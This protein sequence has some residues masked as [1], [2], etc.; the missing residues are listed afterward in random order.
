MTVYGGFAA[1]TLGMLSQ[2]HALDT[3]GNNIANINTGGFR[4]TETR[5][6]TVLSDTV[7]GINSLQSDLGGVRPL[8]INRIDQQGRLI[9]SQNPLDVA[10]SGQGFFVLNTQLNGSGETLYTRDGAFNIGN[11]PL[12]TATADDG[13]TLSVHEG[14][15]VDKNGYF[16]QGWTAAADGTFPTSGSL[17]SLR[18]DQFA[19]ATTGVATT[20]AELSLNLPAGALAGDTETFSFVAYD[21]AFNPQDVTLTFTKGTPVNTW[22]M[23]ATTSQTPV[24]Q[25]DTVTIG[26]TVE[27]GDQYSVT[28]NG[29]AVVY[30]ATGA[31]ADINAIRDNLAAAINANVGVNATVTAAAGAGVGVL[32]V[33][34]NTAG[35]PFTAS[36][37]A[38]DNGV[39][40]AQVDTVTIGGTV[41]AGDTYSVTV[42]GNVVTY[43]VTGGEANLAAV[44]SAFRAAINADPTVGPLVTA[45]DAAAAGELTLTAATAGT[46]FT[47]TA[48]FTDAGGTPDN[49]ASSVNTVANATAA[50]DNTAGLVTTTANVIST[51]TTAPTTI[52]FDGFGQ[53]ATPSPAAINMAL[54]F[55]A[56]PASTATIALDISKVVQ[57]D[58]AFTPLS[59][60]ANGFGRS[61]LRSINFDATGQV[62]ANFTNGT[63]R[64]VY[65]LSLGNF[66]N[67]NALER[68][69]GN[70]F[71]PTE[72]SGTA[73]VSAAGNNGFALFTPN[74]HEVSNVELTDEFSKM[75]LTQNAYNTSATVFRTVD[76]LLATA[77]DLK[78]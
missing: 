26:G 67:P 39:N 62:V 78:R 58:G 21:S 3:I 8:D 32:T 65:K 60:T 64:P 74:A 43:V 6:A 31:E 12:T 41:E 30:T 49:S 47:A 35:T 18:I 57:F 38:V 19:F 54:T 11:G 68:R 27:A 75:I 7:G 50:A 59:F 70:T 13:S 45:T 20:S 71:A 34:A 56:T 40:I 53:V 37:A 4:A 22:T 36:A 44:R 76:E 9:S 28:V 16:V 55:A 72:T 14:Y 29:N 1:S 10:I 24:A 73:T 66:S 17:S 23:T 5:F 46:P 63:F 15:L 2:S 61:N 52:T 48:G 33:T 77:R 69:N 51:T 42:N 25:V